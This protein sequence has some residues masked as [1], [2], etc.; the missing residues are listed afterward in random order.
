[1]NEYLT[2]AQVAA[3][4]GVTERTVRRWCEAGK[5]K[6]TSIGKGAHKTWL[7]DPASIEGIERDSKGRKGK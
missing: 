2:T 1:M 4:K 3:A 6:A 5:I 7:I